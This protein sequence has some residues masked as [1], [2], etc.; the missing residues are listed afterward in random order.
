MVRNS[1]SELTDDPLVV[2]DL[3]LNDDK[4]V[5]HQLQFVPFKI[6]WGESNITGFGG[7]GIVEV[8]RGRGVGALYYL[9][10]CTFPIFFR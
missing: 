6:E 8:D 1:L 10:V 5:K 3:H 2:K 4:P 7:T 9:V